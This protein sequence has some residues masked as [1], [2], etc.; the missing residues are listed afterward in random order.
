MLSNVQECACRV[1][2]KKDKSKPMVLLVSDTDLI[3]VRKIVA[4]SFSEGTPSD[5][6]TWCPSNESPVSVFRYT[7]PVLEPPFHLE[8]CAN[9][10]ILKDREKDG[11]ALWQ[12][13]SEG[14]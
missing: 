1:L 6:K 7:D 14:A 5:G 4:A 10:A 13:A 11:L 9:G 2:D 3:S 8:I 12:K